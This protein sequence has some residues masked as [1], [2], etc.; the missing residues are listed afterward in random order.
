M[1]VLVFKCERH[2][3]GGPGARAAVGGVE[4]PFLAQGSL[5]TLLRDLPPGGSVT[6]LLLRHIMLPI[7]IWGQVRLMVGRRLAHDFVEHV[8]V[9]ALVE[10]IEETL[11]TIG[12]RAL[13]AN[14]GLIL[15]DI[16]LIILIGKQRG[17]QSRYDHCW[18][19]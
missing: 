8:D 1:L 12:R 13:L 14:S 7:D 11:E 10:Q 15:C 3:L 18:K 17:K 4:A 16:T 2:L 9:H 5:S 19:L 6:A